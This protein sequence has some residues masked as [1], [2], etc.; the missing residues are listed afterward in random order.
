M[1]RNDISLEVLKVGIIKTEM[2]FPR[3]DEEGG[4]DKDKG[5]LLWVDRISGHEVTELHL[6]GFGLG[7]KVS[8][9]LL[10]LNFFNYLDLSSIEF[11]GA[12][13]PSFLGSMR[14][15]TYLMD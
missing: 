7:G 14:S 9:A 15:L 3:S 2:M 1:K 11:G 4:D 10:Q 6:H 13:V 12:P 5:R 8:P